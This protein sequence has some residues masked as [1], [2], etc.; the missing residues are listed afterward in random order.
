MRGDVQVL[1]LPV[2]RNN[3]FEMT[4]PEFCDALCALAMVRV[5]D[6]YLPLHHKLEVFLSSVLQPSFKKLVF[7]QQRQ[8][9]PRQ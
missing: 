1:Y 7:K 5:P 4:L 2:D 6:P 8:E 9:H 3:T